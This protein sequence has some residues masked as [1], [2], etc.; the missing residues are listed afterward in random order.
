MAGII[1]GAKKDDNKCGNASN[2]D[3]MV[4]RAESRKR[5]GK[6]QFLQNAIVAVVGASLKVVCGGAEW[7]GDK[8]VGGKKNCQNER[9][10]ATLLT[11]FGME[12]V[13]VLMKGR[14]EITWT[15]NEG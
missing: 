5:R 13:C 12:V 9:N 11:T 4:R 6:K 14:R 7:R 8:G 2:L 15:V 10:D 1:F 3:C